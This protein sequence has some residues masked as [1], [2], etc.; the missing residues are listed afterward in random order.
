MLARHFHERIAGARAAAGEPRADAEL[1]GDFVASLLGRGWPGNVRELRNYIERA[2][3]LGLTTATPTAKRTTPP[4]TLDAHVP[5]HLPLK[6]ARQAWTESFEDIYV[7]SLLRK[8][9]GN[10]TRA[11]ERA[12]VSRRFLQRTIARLGIKPS[13]VGV[14]PKDL[15]GDD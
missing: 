13:D 12:G 15:D 9:N 5:L 14:D 2:V 6:E 4:A 3:S 7:R 1:P 11:A 10:V 8:M